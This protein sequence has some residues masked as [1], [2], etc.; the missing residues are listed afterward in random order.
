MDQARMSGAVLAEMLEK[1]RVRPEPESP[2]CARA[3]VQRLLAGCR[4]RFQFQKTHEFQSWVPAG[5]AMMPGPCS[6]RSCWAPSGDRVKEADSAG[7]HMHSSKIRV[8]SH[9]AH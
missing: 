5:T 2:C 6:A 4:D 8:S 7:S 1:M 3:A 9:D